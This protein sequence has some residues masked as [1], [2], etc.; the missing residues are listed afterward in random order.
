MINNKVIFA[1]FGGQGV[2]SLGQ[3]VAQMAL[4]KDLNVTW[5][6]LYGAEMRGGTANCSVIYSE[7]L[8]GSPIISNDLETLVV[9]NTP[10]LDKFEQDVIPGGTIIVNSSVVD[11][12]VNRDDVTVYYIDATNIAINEL[13][14]AKVANMVMLGSFIHAFDN[15]KLEDGIAV[16]QEKFASKEKLVALNE[17]AAKCG[18]DRVEKK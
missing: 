4:R 3:I 17:Q 18:Y 2:L 15:F 9:M 16:M 10:S 13:N 5:L 6:P 1:G 11:R 7:N 8:V 12:K 14:N